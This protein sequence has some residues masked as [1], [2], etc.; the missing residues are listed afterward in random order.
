MPTNPSRRGFQYWRTSPGAVEPHDPVL[1]G[2]DGKEHQAKGNG[3]EAIVAEAL[4]F[5]RDAAKQDKPFLVVIWTS[6]P[7]GPYEPPSEIVA[8]YDRKQ[9]S[10]YACEITAMDRALGMLRDGLRDLKIAENTLLWFNSDNGWSGSDRVPPLR[11]GKT[12][13]W[14]GG[15]R[16]P[17]VIEWPARIKPGSH[18]SVPISC[19]DL[20]P[21][22]GS[23]VGA[24]DL[25]MR[26][27][28][29][30]IDL[31]PLFDGKMTK[32]PKPIPF[33]WFGQVGLIDNRYKICRGDPGSKR[34]QPD[35]WHLYDIEQD[36]IEEYNLAAERPELL[37]HLRKDL[38]AW[39]Q[40]E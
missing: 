38:N 34:P 31:L 11:G 12:T 13:C 5:I 37:E 30:G 14:E 25:K 2:E 20:M 27:P 39:L 18:S 33:A 15:I 6:D 32:R 19:M 21:T 28:A 36:P 29:D 22:L 40:W 16:V 3:S 17:A 24:R 8:M 23:L 7:H 1:V 26:V 10:G 35:Q 4:K 9:R